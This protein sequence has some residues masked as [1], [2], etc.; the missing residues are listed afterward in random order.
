MLF[1]MFWRKYMDCHRKRMT[2]EECRILSNKIQNTVLELSEW[3]SAGNI[4]IYK[5]IGNEVSTDKLIYDATMQSNKV[6]YYPTPEPRDN[7]TDV[8]LVIVPG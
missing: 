8:D 6:I 7:V 2:T 1:K 5:S 3:K 4:N